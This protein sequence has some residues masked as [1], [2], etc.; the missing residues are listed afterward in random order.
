[1]ESNL[2]GALSS[3]MKHDP[4]L[5]VLGLVSCFYVSIVMIVSNNG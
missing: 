5:F 3:C 1:M 4:I 2:G